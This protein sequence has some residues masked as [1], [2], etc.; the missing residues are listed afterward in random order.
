MARLVIGLF[1]A[2]GLLL[3]PTSSMKLEG[4]KT[5]QSYD[6]YAIEGSIMSA[7][8][9]KQEQDRKGRLFWG[10]SELFSIYLSHLEC[11]VRVVVV[12]VV[13][14]DDHRGRMLP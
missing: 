9:N 10:V 12:V 8:E 11:E 2:F 1:V 4:F 5:D 3:E 6:T 7:K 14:S 13:F